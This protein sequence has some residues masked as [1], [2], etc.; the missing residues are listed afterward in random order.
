MNLGPRTRLPGFLLATFAV[1][2][3]AWFACSRPGAPGGWFFAL[4]GPVFLFGVFAPS[5]VAIALAAFS[6]GGPGVRSLLS[7]ILKY[8]VHP[9]FYVFALSYMAG[10]RLLAALIHRLVEGVW[11]ALSETPWYLLLGAVFISTW[12][13]AGEEVGFRGYALPRLAARLGLGGAS[14]VLG[15]VWAVWHLPLFFIPGT[16]SDGQSFP[17]YLMYVTA[18]SVFLT[19]LYWRTE[20]SLL[21]VMIA[22]ASVNNTGQIVRA[23]LP[24]A[25]P[26][27]SLEGSLMVWLTLAIIWSIAA[28][29]LVRMRGGRLGP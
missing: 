15:V 14:L 11:P 8:E 20:G 2:W 21:L 12:T 13:Q 24:Y 1:T 27:F 6:E 17:I 23:A 5:L 7:G 10:S 22:H 9:R 19:W 25:V 4:G 3:L 18:L 16:G 29:L 26:T 28:V